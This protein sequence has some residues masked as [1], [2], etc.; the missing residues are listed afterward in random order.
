M[1]AIS[2]AMQDK[3]CL[4][5]WFPR[6]QAGNVPVP[7]TEIISTEG[8]DLTQLLDG[9][10]P[11]G[12]DLFMWRMKDA[13]AHIGE[14]AFLRTGHTAVKHS[15][16]RTC[17]LKSAADLANHVAYLVDISVCFDLPTNVWAVRELL[18]TTPLITMPNY[19][20]MPL[21]TEIRAFI[22]DG[23]KICAH[24]YWPMKAIFQGIQNR[25]G[26]L[27]AEEPPLESPERLVASQMFNKSISANDPVAANDLAATVAAIFK[28][29][30]AWSVDMLKTKDGKFV[31]TDMAQA[32]RSFHWENC[33]HR[34]SFVA[35]PITQPEV[36]DGGS[37]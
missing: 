23:R 2:K 8:C 32:H 21:V 22:R 4:S 19:G 28:D 29:D 34:S 30:G 6:L 35:P 15:W 24:P 13:V 33:P 18:P 1:T 27:V 17:F 12:Y 5:Y 14:P 9:N 26:G 16:N 37:N 20:D 11:D 25:G 10:T 31:V 7:K 36:P 3:N